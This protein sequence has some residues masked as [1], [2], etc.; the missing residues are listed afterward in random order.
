[1]SEKR[2]F[3]KVYEKPDA[4]IWTLE[5]PPQILRDLVEDGTIKPCKTLDV[6]CGEGTA[7]VYLAKKGFEVTGIDFVENA[8]EYARDRANKAGAEVEF[9]VMDATDLSGL[10]EKFDFIFEWALIHHLKSEQVAPYLKQIPKLLNPGGL[11]LTNS[12]NIES[13]LYGQAGER[14]R[15]TFL[16]TELLYHSQEEMEQLLSQD[17][18]VIKKEIIPLVGKG[19]QQIGNFFLVRKK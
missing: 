2:A 16:G 13:P 5:E 7:A 9:K 17:F 8:I 6:A 10:N 18:M 4:A 15:K 1:M 12:F 14:V 3:E 11:Y 19:V